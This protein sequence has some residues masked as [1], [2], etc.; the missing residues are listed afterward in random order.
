MIRFENRLEIQ[1]EMTSWSAISQKPRM[2]HAVGLKCHVVSQSTPSRDVAG[3]SHRSGVVVKHSVQFV[4]RTKSVER[5]Y[6]FQALQTRL[7]LT[8]YRDAAPL[9]NGT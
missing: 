5:G 8:I 4:S 7:V 9:R 1:K 3:E 2:H 6:Q